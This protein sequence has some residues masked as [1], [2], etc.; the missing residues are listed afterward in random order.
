MFMCCY[1]FQVR[2]G[3]HINYYK[4]TLYVNLDGFYCQV[5]LALAVAR[6]TGNI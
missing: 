3:N 5:R 4:C 2:A 1:N 6:Q